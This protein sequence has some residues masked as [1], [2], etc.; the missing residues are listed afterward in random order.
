MQAIILAAGAGTR[1]GLDLPKCL[2]KVAGKTLLQN[3]IETIKAIDDTALITVVAG[4]KAREVEQEIYS[5]R[6]IYPLVKMVL[7]TEAQ[8][9]GIVRSLELANETIFEEDVLRISGDIYFA[10]DNTLADIIK[11]HSSIGVQPVPDYR[12]ETVVVRDEDLVLT[13]GHSPDDVEWLDVDYFA[14]GDFKRLLL[15]SSWYR[16]HSQHFFQLLRHAYRARTIRLATTTLQ[17]VCEIDTPKDLEY[18]CK[19]LG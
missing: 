8:N 16:E 1:L 9:L 12:G 7:N 10:K 5:L 11:P 13:R 17:G 6:S 14:Q 4:F 2:V 18:V 3:Q 19:N 15:A